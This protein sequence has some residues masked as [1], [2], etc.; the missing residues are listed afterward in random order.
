MVSASLGQTIALVMER[1]ATTLGIDLI[2]RGQ[3]E[4][5]RDV[6]TDM[7]KVNSIDV[8]ALPD[9]GDTLLFVTPLVSKTFDILL[10][11]NCEF[12]LRSVAVLGPII[13][14]EGVEVDPSK[15]EAVNILPRPLDPTDIKSFLGM[16]GYY[17]GF[18]DE[19]ASLASPFKP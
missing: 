8:Y 18:V 2:Q 13:S 6:V 7:L 15:I 16:A 9:P 4:T 11:S 14:S 12:W 5:S 19:F 3:Q 1:V 10:P 17:R